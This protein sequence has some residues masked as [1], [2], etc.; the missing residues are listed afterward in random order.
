MLLSL[1]EVWSLYWETY[2]LHRI[3]GCLSL[4]KHGALGYPMQVWK[5]ILKTQQ[6]LLKRSIMQDKEDRGGKRVVW[7]VVFFLFLV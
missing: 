5:Q 6:K 3:R 1:F 7:V 2:G 4:D